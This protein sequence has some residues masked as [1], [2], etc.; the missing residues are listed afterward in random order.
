M[1]L[2][3]SLLAM[4]L[5][6]TFILAAGCDRTDTQSQPGLE[7]SE[8]APQAKRGGPEM[9]A[10]KL[11]AR[12]KPMQFAPEA[13]PPQANA[14]MAQDGET[15]VKPGG[16]EVKANGLGDQKPLVKAGTARVLT[17][18]PAPKAN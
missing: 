18:T 9:R 2:S 15:P 4:C 3:P 13:L 16:L 14:P 5:G 7:A 10:N 8:S 6:G 1:K 12:G 11:Q 17:K